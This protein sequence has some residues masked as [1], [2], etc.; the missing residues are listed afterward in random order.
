M[1]GAEKARDAS[2]DTVAESEQEYLERAQE[3]FVEVTEPDLGPFQEAA[4]PVY[5]EV[6]DVMGEKIISD[7]QTF[8]K[9][10]R[11]N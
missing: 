3:E 8:L 5:K 4:Q 6:E 10:Y 11:N 2:R 7:I 1:E 9:D